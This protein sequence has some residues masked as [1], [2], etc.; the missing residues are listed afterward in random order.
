MVD[1][2]VK[3]ILN[4]IKMHGTTIKTIKFTEDQL[5]LTSAVLFS[6][7]TRKVYISL[8]RTKFC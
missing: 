4:L 5:T 8:N 1:L 3:R 7:S 2:L 6:N